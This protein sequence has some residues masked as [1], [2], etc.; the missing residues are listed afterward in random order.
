[1]TSPGNGRPNAFQ[2]RMSE[3][4]REV[5][6]QRQR[7]ASE[8]GVGDQF[9]AALRLIWERLRFDPVTFGEPQFRLPALNLLVC[10]A[11][12]APLV[13]DYGVHEERRLVFIRGFKILS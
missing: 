4:T 5:L 7:E 13:V 3:H 1:M 2:V 6:K 11:V 9:L 8:A 12:V 10:Q